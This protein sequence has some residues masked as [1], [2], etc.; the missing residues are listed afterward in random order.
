MDRL[1]FGVAVLLLLFLGGAG[2]MHSQARLD[3]LKPETGFR[4]IQYLPKGEALKIVAFGFDAPLADILYLKG[5]IYWA[6]NA[7]AQ[8]TGDPDAAYLYLHDLFDAV[9]DLNPAFKA[10]YINGGVLIGSSGKKRVEAAR[11]LFEKGVERFPE[12]WRFYVRL[13]SLALIQMDDLK[14]AGTYY[15]EAAKCPGVPREI[16]RAW[17]GFEQMVIDEDQASPLR[18]IDLEIAQWNAVLEDPRSAEEVRRYARRDLDRLR[19]QRAEIMLTRAAQAYRER[20]GHPP[21]DLAT[22][23]RA[24]LGG[25]LLPQEEVARLQEAPYHEGATWDDWRVLPD[26]Q[27]RSLREV[28]R[29]VRLFN[30]FVHNARVTFAAR[31]EREAESLEELVEAGLLSNRPR[32]PLAALGYRLVYDEAEGVLRSVPSLPPAPPAAGR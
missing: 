7:R 1:R 19:T 3:A 27:V 5:L 15:R 29:V 21:A 11:Q 32:H 28:A 31:R 8:A 4:E 17:R 18:R 20:T 14:L 23:F 30:A 9:T 10:A 13:G 6:E 25:G 24:I 22:L 2:V 12:D 16:I 26:G